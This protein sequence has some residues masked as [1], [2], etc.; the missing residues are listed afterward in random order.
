MSET[1]THGARRILVSKGPAS[2]R[3]RAL[4]PRLTDIVIVLLAGALLTACGS[5]AKGSAPTT[6]PATSS[7][8]SAQ[9]AI[10]PTLRVTA[11][12]SGHCVAAGVAGNSSYRCFAGNGIYDPCF[13][14]VGA[15]SGPLLCT[16]NPAGPQVVQFDVG[17]LPG[18]LSGAPENRPWAMRI[19]NGQ[20]CVLINAAWGGLGPFQ[21]QPAPPGP[22]A[23]CHVP[24]QAVPWWTAAC[25]DQTSD[26]SPFTTYEVDTAWL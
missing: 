7:S 8:T 14:R 17:I 1:L 10:A 11:T 22:L 25:Q 4:L 23:D 12:V 2:H 9:G 15:T 5:S 21:C 16:S 13:A 6:R 20:I 19:S 26:S 24:E 18:P 3:C